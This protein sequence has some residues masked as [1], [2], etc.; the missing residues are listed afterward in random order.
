MKPVPTATRTMP[1]QEEASTGID[2]Q[3]CPAM[4]TSPP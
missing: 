4:M 1:S 2:R 3:M